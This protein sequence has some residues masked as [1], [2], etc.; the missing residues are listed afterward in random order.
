[1]RGRHGWRIGIAVATGLALAGSTT[2]PV[3]AQY[4]GQ[5]KVQYRTFDFSVLKTEHFDVYYY[6]EERAGV[7]M[8]ARMAERWHARL[9]QLLHH[10]L[11]GRQPLI[12]YASASDFQ[13]TNVVQG[14]G[15]GTGGVTESARRR[16]V[17]PFA[18][19]IADTDHV[20]GHE[21]VHAFQY[22]I[23]TALAKRG[24]R[25]AGVER[26]PL[27]F[28]EGMAEYFSIGPR[29]PLTAMWVRD[30][31]VHEKLPRIKDLNDPRYFPYRW[32]QALWAYIG[33]R[34][35]DKAVADLLAMAVDEGD[36]DKAF[37]SIL[38]L[39]TDELSTQWQ[40]ALRQQVRAYG[41]A[42]RVVAPPG[43]LLTPAGSLGSSINVSPAL[44]PDGTRVAFLSSRGL[45]SIDLYVA[46][47]RTGEQVKRLTSTDVDP[48]FESLQFISSAGTWD[49]TGKQL[50]VTAVASG[51]PILAIYDV[52]RGSR[53]REI[54]L[55]G[56]DGAL[57]P[58]WSPDG[59][60]VAVVGMRGGTTD[61][62]SV[63]V[64]S[65]R[66]DRLTNDAYSE[67]HPAWSPDSRRLAV[68]TD[69]FTADLKTVSPGDLRLGVLDVGTRQ[70]QEIRTFAKGKAMQP[71]W[72]REGDA[73]AFIGDPDGIAN[74]YRVD[75]AGGEPT[76]LTSVATG[77]SGITE[78]S[79][80]LS[81]A[82][83][84]FA[85]TVFDDGEYRL[86]TVEMNALTP[87]TTAAPVPART[88]GV[89]AARL[90][91]IE[92]PPRASTAILANETIGLPP[93]T[94]VG[95]QQEYSPRLHLDYAAQPTVAV[96]ADRFGGFGGGGIALLFSDMLGEHN[97]G[98]AFQASTSFDEDFST[99][100]LGGAVVYQNLRHRL[101]WGV[102][103]DQSPYR[104]GFVSEVGAI[105]D[106][107][108]AIVDQ[109][110][111]YRQADRG[112]TG[113][114][115]Y[116]LSRA[117]RIEGT[118]G[119]R[120]LTFDQIVRTTAVDIETG[121]I[122]LDD[123]QHAPGL[124]GLNLGQ[125]GAALVYD[126]SSFGA[127]SPIYGQR[128]R[129]EVTPTF[130]SI[131]YTGVLL[132]YRRYFMP[133][134]L[135]TIAG[136]VMHYGRY[137]AGSEDPRLFP[138]F[139][140]YPS[141]VRGYDVGTFETTEC[142]PTVDGSC[143]TFDRLVGSRMLVGNLEFRFPLLKPFGARQNVYGPVPVEV[144]AFLDGGVAWTQQDKPT[145]AGGDRKGVSSVGLALR[146]NA[147]GFAIVQLDM[148]KPLQRPDRGWVF[149]FSLSPGF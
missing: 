29:S 34:W 118:V 79:P 88:D 90:P 141:L 137:G 17:L 148:A 96:G 89:D 3:E 105:V 74:I 135:Y 127:T 62:Y 60:H 146:A 142:P 87:A 133:K 11:T 31:V 20:I 114:A 81:L 147:F 80:A 108:P 15:E 35:G 145:F 85:Y 84:R 55:E 19:T 123:K 23:G 100:D 28:I 36:I 109:S 39:K 32:G 92:S 67:L 69:R 51:R 4:F 112:V 71:Q 72:T 103:L 140:G 101:N 52:D 24:R 7:D 9:T 115:S 82:A 44:S 10:Q 124:E 75:A 42:T 86:Y 98:V 25:V 63:E 27:W 93:A 117:Q 16:I 66:L 132:D 119:Y 78:T 120:N 110:V 91:P 13:Q 8:A 97:L 128:Y 143:P 33:G 41:A 61:L 54:P 18:G 83:G 111:L 64:E 121:D 65:G 116:P 76:R 50:A 2:A 113:M 59:A 126:T 26:L 38:G 5:N 21:L 99:A 139:L 122:L 45:F 40:T 49:P 37:Q 46:D 130:G 43:A 1:M 102:S 149:Q 104:T 30:A 57:N 107:R 56:L 138:L 134:Q 58:A 73:V 144:A 129:F 6:P 48:H 14:I 94:N 47:S 12:L 70:M 53:L 68:S 95:T 131:R 125:A 106:G 136:R 22:D 77:V